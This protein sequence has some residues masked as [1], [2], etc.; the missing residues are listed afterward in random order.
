MPGTT[1]RDKGVLVGFGPGVVQI[2]A[3][4]PTQP[5]IAFATPQPAGRLRFFY[6]SFLRMFHGHVRGKLSVDDPRLSPRRTELLSKSI[7]G[8]GERRGPV[9]QSDYLRLWF[10]GG[11]G[12]ATRWLDRPVAGIFT[13]QTTHS[14]FLVAV[15]TVARSCRCRLSGAIAGSVGEA[16]IR[17][18]IPSDVASSPGGEFRC[19]LRLAPSGRCGSGMSRAGI[20]TGIVWA[21]ETAVA[22][23]D[24]RSRGE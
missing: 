20:V 16:F 5:G 1:P 21:A 23:D 17:K 8:L 6:C 11:V 22:G 4:G 12:N 3:G 18:P 24:R 15:V 7:I 10:A 9:R 19:S 13:D 14:A 2:L